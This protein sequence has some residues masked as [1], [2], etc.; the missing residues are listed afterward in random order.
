MKERKPSFKQRLE[1]N[2]A[3]FM[4]IYETYPNLSVRLKRK[5][6]LRLYTKAK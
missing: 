2:H 4:R 6:Y 1:R 3:L 5:L